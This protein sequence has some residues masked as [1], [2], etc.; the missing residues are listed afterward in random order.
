MKIGWVA[1]LAI[2]CLTSCEYEEVEREIGYKGKARV[3]PWL[4]AERFIE[5]SGGQVNPVISWVDPE[6][7]DSVWMMPASVLDNA[8]FVSRVED[9]AYDG[10]HLILLVEHAD[11]SV[12][13]WSGAEIEPKISSELLEMLDF[14]DISLETSGKAKAE[15]ID[16]LGTKYRVNADSDAVVSSLENDGG[17]FVSEIFGDGRI[18]VITDARI[19][20]SRW[21]DEN[22]HAALFAALIDFDG[23]PGTVGIMRGAELSFWKLLAENLGPLLIGLLAWL[24]IWLWQNMSRFGPIEEESVASASR[25][26]EH[27]LEAIGHFHWKHDRAAAL[28]SPLREQVLDA[29]QRVLSQS[30]SAENDRF[31]FL[32]ERASLPLERVTRVLSATVPTDANSLALLTADLQKLQ[33]SLQET[34]KS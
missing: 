26:Y 22:E 10:G 28:I 24:V 12:N 20:R 19:F 18:T 34:S 23:S 29:G 1:G 17:V 13:D 5:S 6:P 7:G 33:H 2:L 21:I 9:W 31:H 16:F 3:N 30:G 8:R 15:E 27:H 32:A 4:A 14:A 11:A 25:G